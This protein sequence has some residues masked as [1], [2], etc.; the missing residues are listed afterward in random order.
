MHKRKRSSCDPTIEF[1]NNI[2]SS[3]NYCEEIT[4]SVDE[5]RSSCIIAELNH[6]GDT[7]GFAIDF[8]C[9]AGLY[10]PHL[11][12]RFKK[13]IGCDWSVELLRLAAENVKRKKSGH[14]V[15]VHPHKTDLTKMT[16]MC[17]VLESADRDASFPATD[18]G[19]TKAS[20]G[21]CTN[22]IL[23]PEPKDQRAILRVIRGHICHGGHLLL[24]VPS[25]ESVLFVDWVLRRWQGPTV[26]ENEGISSRSSNTKRDIARGVVKRGTSPA[27]R[28]Q[29]YIKEQIV[30]M[31]RDAG[32]K[33]LRVQK[34]EYGWST[35]FDIPSKGRLPKR[36]ASLGCAMRPWD[37]LLVLRAD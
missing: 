36:I 27:V 25:M 13:V 15:Y 4:S 1:W 19:S 28:T 26:H 21:V 5:T 17:R 12:K 16:S 14:N 33:C 23:S 34:V 11:S 31:T 35:E 10:L 30:A 29:H 37:W 18:S 6:F 9:G 7:E 32:F 2:K 24:L 8:G 20:F 22:V 3:K